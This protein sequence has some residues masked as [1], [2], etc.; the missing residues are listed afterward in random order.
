MAIRGGLSGQFAQ[1]R[2]RVNRQRAVPV[3]TGGCVWPNSQVDAV[4]L[5]N[6]NAKTACALVRIHL[7]DE[8]A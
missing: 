8:V 6:E 2:R 4:V 7:I 5:S 1:A 3:P